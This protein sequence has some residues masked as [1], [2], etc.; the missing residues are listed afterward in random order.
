M[1][2][3]V[4]VALR[5]GDILLQNVRLCGWVKSL[6][7]AWWI[8]CP[9]IPR[10]A[11]VPCDDDIFLGWGRCIICICHFCYRTSSFNCR[12]FWFAL[13]SSPVYTQCGPNIFAQ[14]SRIMEQNV[15]TTFSFPKPLSE[16]EELETLGC[17]KVLL[18]FLMRFDGHF[19]PNQHQQQCLPLFESILDGQISRHLL[20]T[21]FRLEIKNTT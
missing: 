2:C 8:I 7:E 16:S 5:T 10:S 12:Q 20:P 4:T 6:G 11:Q 1:I 18:S 14:V 19:W 9:L 15:H 3:V 21:P 13:E 17:S